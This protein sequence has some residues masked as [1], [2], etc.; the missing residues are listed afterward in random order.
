MGNV[1]KCGSVGDFMIYLFNHKNIIHLYLYIYM[2]MRLVWLLQICIYELLTE[3]KNWG[4]NN[5]I[6]Q[7]IKNINTFLSILMTK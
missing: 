4:I 1:K 6:K 7:K 5:A 2:H 3:E